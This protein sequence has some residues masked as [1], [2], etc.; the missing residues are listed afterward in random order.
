MSLKGHAL[1]EYE[2]EVS[3]FKNRSTFHSTGHSI[4]KLGH[5]LDLNL[6]VFPLQ[7]TQIIQIFSE[8]Y[9]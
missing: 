4:F 8:P 1:S 2:A 3:T 7:A 6:Y 5:T 9:I